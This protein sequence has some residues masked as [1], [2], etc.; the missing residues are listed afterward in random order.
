MKNHFLIIIVFFLIFFSQEVISKQNRIA[1]VIGNSAYKDA[2]LKN[3]SNDAK[4]MAKELSKHG[5]Q[6]DSLINATQRQMEEA[7]RK[8][9]KQLNQK[10]SVGLFY[11]A[12]HGLQVNNRNFL[13]PVDAKIASE[14][15][16][17]YESVDA[18]RILG[19]ME[20][21]ENNLNM[22]ILDA[23]RN[24]PFTRSFRSSTRG[25]A[26]MHAPNGS[27]ILYATSPGD[28]A[29]D[30]DGN[31]GLFTEKLLKFINKKGL[32]I[33]D[34]F[35][36]TAIEVS[37]ASN[38]KQVPYF[39]GVILGN[40][41][42]TDSIV[43]N[44][45]TAKENKDTIN[46]INIGQEDKFWDTVTKDDSK[47]MYQ[48]YVEQYPN[49][50]YKSL[51]LIKINQKSLKNIQGKEPIIE[52]TQ[53]TGEQIKKLIVGNTLK[54]NHKRKNFD[55]EMYIGAGGD[56][57]EKRS[58]S[59]D[60]F[61]TWH[62][63]SHSEFCFKFIDHEKTYCRIIEPTSNNKYGIIKNESTIVREFEV[64]QGNKLSWF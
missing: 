39:E 22:M 44:N 35:K 55:F 20:L 47:E 56:F 27:V 40:F 61:G 54:G 33:E 59:R 26:K 4:A 14:A 31:N 50:N 7:I 12:G 24:N 19:Q 23:C 17:Q 2:P 32:K 63:N 8:F 60:R 15:D 11:F 18:G 28:V 6:V 41:Y 30:G 43:F 46:R 57:K 64:I 48:A 53:L 51:A 5:F 10:N 13:V 49:G 37:H 1:L 52:Q 58:N 62:I 16:V 3:P 25:L 29:A 45:N 38:K 42:F 34:V 21:A 9:G 36:Q